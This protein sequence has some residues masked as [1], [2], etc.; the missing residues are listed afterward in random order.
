MLYTVCLA[1]L[2]TKAV[3]F[4]AILRKKS[5]LSFLNVSDAG[6]TFSWD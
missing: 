1:F 2:Q 4:L 3:N 5:K 6:I